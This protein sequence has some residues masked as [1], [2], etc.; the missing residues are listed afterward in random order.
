MEVREGGNGGWD[1]AEEGVFGEVESGEMG[2]LRNLR[3]EGAGVAGGVECD[4]GDTGGV[5]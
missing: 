4:L 3:G 1:W 2:E 5:R